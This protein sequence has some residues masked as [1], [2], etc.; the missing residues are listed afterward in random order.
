LAIREAAR[1]ANRHFLYA[2]NVG[3]GLPILQTL[4]DL[5]ATGDEIQLIQGV[6]SGTLSY[7]FNQY[8]GTQRFSEIVRY[9]RD[10]G[11]TEPDPRDDLSGQDVM[12]KLVILAREAGFFLEPADVVVESLV[13]MP[14]TSISPVEFLSR[15]E[16]MD[17]EMAAKLDEA[18]TRRLKLRFVASFDRA[19]NKA[20]V[21]LEMVSSTH[22]FA[23]VTGT[24]NVV[25]FTTSRYHTQPLV[26]RGPGAGPEVTAAGVFADL[27]R[28]S[29][30]L[31]AMS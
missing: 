31:G 21:G 27:L 17:E 2:T 18:K 22:A 3:A 6:L 1:E 12:R 20:R 9:A 14:L 26:I 24:D 11:Y 29:R 4:R 8:D 19:L 7:I 15:L 23:Q 28:L 10:Q 16:E 5:C 13:P 30:Y 25:S